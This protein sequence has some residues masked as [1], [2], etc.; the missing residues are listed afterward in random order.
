MLPRPKCPTG[1]TVYLKVKKRYLGFSPKAKALY[2]LV[3]HL[4]IGTANKFCQRTSDYIPINKD[5]VIQQYSVGQSNKYFVGNESILE[6]CK[7][8]IANVKVLKVE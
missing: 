1:W 4:D 6:M 3:L 7:E 8:L 2:P 5:T